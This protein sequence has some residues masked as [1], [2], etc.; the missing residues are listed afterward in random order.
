MN[1][2]SFGGEDSHVDV[3]GDHAKNIRKVGADSNVS[4]ST[5]KKR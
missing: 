4:F 2:A 5:T 1:F 3:Q